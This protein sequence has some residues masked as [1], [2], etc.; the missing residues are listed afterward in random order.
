ADIRFA[1]GTSIA[2]GSGTT[3]VLLAEDPG[4]RLIL[5]GGHVIAD[6]AKQVDAPLEIATPHSRLTVLGTRFT[7][8]VDNERTA[9]AV[10]EGRVAMDDLRS[11]ERQLVGAGHAHSVG[12]A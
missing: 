1:D 5:S 11:G 4:K 3:V 7:V 9:L 10:S 6:V 8:E 2:L 12:P